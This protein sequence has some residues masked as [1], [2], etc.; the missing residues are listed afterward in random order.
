[1]SLSDE[2][3]IAIAREYF[4]LSDLGDPKILELFHADAT[5]Y[6]PKFGVGRGK[7]SILDMVAGFAGVLEWIRHDQAKFVFIPSGD[8]LAVEGV[9]AGKMRSGS[10]K[11]GET[12]GGRFCNVFEFRGERIA[13]L[14]V[15]LDPDY[16]G[17]DEPRFRWGRENRP[18]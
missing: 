6:F 14:Y 1:M 11:G 17:E 16:L 4:R 15:Y 10:W 2:Q 3:K 9:S 18:W 5:F 7:S 8:R 12:V 13:R